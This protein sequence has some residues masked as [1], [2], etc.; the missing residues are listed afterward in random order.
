V[1]L[2]T[3]YTDLLLSAAIAAGLTLALLLGFAKQK[4]LTANRFLSLVLVAL[5]SWML[6]L[7]RFS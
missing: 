7:R 4:D 6:G 1:G 2:N 5:V 3:L